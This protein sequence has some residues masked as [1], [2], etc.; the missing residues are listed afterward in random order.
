MYGKS[1]GN[2]QGWMEESVGNHDRKPVVTCKCGCGTVLHKNNWGR[3]QVCVPGH[4]R[5]MLA[6][7][8]E[9][10]REEYKSLLENAPFCAC[11][12]G[13]RTRP[14]CG[15]SL[16]QFIR[17]RGA[18]AFYKFIQG[19]DQR[20]KSWHVLMEEQERSAI[21]GSLLGDSSILYPHKGST[22]PRITFNH[23]EPQAAWA[24]HKAHY[25]AR[26]GCKI[27]QKNN[28][29]YGS[30]T[31]SGTTGCIPALAD[32]HHLCIKDGKK[33]VTREWL[34]QIGD[35]GL[36]WWICDDGSCSLRGLLLHT[37]GYP[38]AENEIICQWFADHYGTASIHTGKS[39][40]HWIYLSADAQRK[41]LPVVEQ[42]IPV[43]MQY[44]L[45]SCRKCAASTPKRNRL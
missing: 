20:G 37:E 17:T 15:E 9:Q 33:S 21:L 18:R 7:S 12:C 3:Q 19:H 25:L 40:H 41:I 5:R 2:D 27:T 31:V 1:P 35:I 10:W 13:K 26:L 32:I 11:G 39:G 45:A 44:K 22:A 38:L 8:Y 16:E 30:I 6:K 34:D 23:G 14:K 36:A 42:Y 43:S 28:A 4:Q 24:E 29:G